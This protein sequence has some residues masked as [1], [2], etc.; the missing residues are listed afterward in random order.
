M[1]GPRSVAHARLPGRAARLAGAVVLVALVLGG[2]GG[3]RAAQ[4][5]GTPGPWA[6]F[7]GDAAH[8][9]L[10]ASG[11]AP[12]YVRAWTH[13]V[14]PTDVKQHSFGV[15][16]PVIDGT[17]VYAAS[18]SALSALDLSSGAERWSVDRQGAPSTPAVAEAG[19][20]RLVL[21]TDT[22]D[23]GA[24]ELRAVDADTGKDA[25][26][27]PAALPA[28]SRT[29][30]TVDGGTAYVG[31][32]NGHVVAVDAATGKQTWS[33][34]IGGEPKGPLAV[35]DGNVYAVPL[36]HDFSTS[37]SA[38]IVALAASDGS[39]S[40]RVTSQPASPF[41]SLPA[42]ADGSVVLVAPQAV[43]DAHV[44]GLDAADGT[45]RWSV[46]INLYSFYFGAPA[47]TPDA[48]Y[49]GDVNG[50]LHAV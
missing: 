6:Q 26:D 30:V 15:S 35:G 3:A 2:S 4:P 36:S 21:F 25:W 5:E 9:G 37:V 22:T 27:A 23:E 20:R 13:P 38:S 17:T 29:G 32:A 28:V 41:A 49:S 7:Q 12:P 31:D 11:P 48:V 14:A 8:D 46:R 1:L 40:W 42:A 47:V 45:E 19:G 16:A 24:G 39:I 33:V 50:G 43:G 44:V 18:G 34:S 10:A